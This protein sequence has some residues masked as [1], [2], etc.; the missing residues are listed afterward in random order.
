MKAA[1]QKTDNKDMFSCRLVKLFRIEPVAS[2]TARPICA[3]YGSISTVN[4]P[5]LPANS[6][7]SSPSPAIFSSTVWKVVSVSTAENFQH[8]WSASILKSG[9]TAD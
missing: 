6:V 8:L 7:R 3:L 1:L 2:R 5:R 4:V 9:F